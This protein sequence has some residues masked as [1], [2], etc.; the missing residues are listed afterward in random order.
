L[1]E[2]KPKGTLRL[3]QHRLYTGHLCLQIHV[4]DISNVKVTYAQPPP[5]EI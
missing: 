2:D 3:P 1:K 4:R 5:S